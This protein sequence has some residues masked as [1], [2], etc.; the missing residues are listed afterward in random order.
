MEK[1]DE[2]PVEPWRPTLNTSP[3]KSY[4]PELI[5]SSGSDIVKVSR[6]EA[7]S[8]NMRLFGMDVT[9]ASPKQK[10]KGKG[11]GKTKTWRVKH[12]RQ[13]DFEEDEEEDFPVFS[14]E[15]EDYSQMI[16]RTGPGPTVKAFNH[17]ATRIPG[18]EGLLLDT[19]AVDNLSG[20]APIQRQGDIAAKHGHPVVWEQL[21]KSKN[22][23]GVGGA[24]KTCTQ[25][26]VV[27]GKLEN[28]VLIKY[29]APVI[30]DS[31]VPPLH[32]LDSMASMNTYVGTKHGKLAMIPDGTDNDII[33]P[34]GTTF[35]QCQR[36]PSRH[37]IITTSNWDASPAV[38]P[39]TVPGGGVPYPS[40]E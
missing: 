37:W 17:S 16:V 14:W 5:G 34:K 12:N 7:K 8:R 30:S 18:K 27:T 39:A 32:G 13:S 19:G 35:I 20:D 11:K 36:A 21:L 9:A 38:Y 33:W 40:S 3:W 25:Q 31:E 15:E 2:T 26:A 29:H 24:A 28:G 23:S 4:D 1:S 6:E 10:G 22:V